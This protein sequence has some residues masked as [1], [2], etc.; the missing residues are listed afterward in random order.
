MTNII[1]AQGKPL[2]FPQHFFFG[3]NSMNFKVLHV[4]V[5]KLEYHHKQYLQVIHACIDTLPSHLFLLNVQL[6]SV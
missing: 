3:Y 6:I 1:C 5:T 4:C 2:P